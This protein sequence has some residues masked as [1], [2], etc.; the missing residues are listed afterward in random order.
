ML[1]PIQRGAIP[2][3]P[4]SGPGLP[5]VIRA[6]HGAL[7]IDSRKAAIILWA[8]REDR[9]RARLR[10]LL[11]GGSPVGALEKPAFAAR[12][13]KTRG[14]ARG[15]QSHHCLAGKPTRC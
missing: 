13:H 8:D 9:D 15:G 2:A 1:P 11:P 14:S 4:G 5:A 6:E 3:L 12:V 10:K 7:R